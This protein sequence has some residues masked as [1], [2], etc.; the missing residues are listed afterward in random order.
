MLPVPAEIDPRNIE[1]KEKVISQGLLTAEATDRWK[2][3]IKVDRH[4]MRDPAPYRVYEAKTQIETPD[5][6]LRLSLIMD[7]LKD[8]MEGK[9]TS[10][11]KEMPAILV[12]DVWMAR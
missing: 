3:C 8:N 10:H 11:G 12:G 2:K 6:S 4:I 1:L 7:K 9:K 5:A